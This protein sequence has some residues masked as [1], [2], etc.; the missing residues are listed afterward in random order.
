M[1]NVAF[2]NVMGDSLSA[3]YGLAPSQG[4]VALTA[5]RVGKTKPGWRVVNA[6]ISGETTSGGNSRLPQLLARYQPSV[7]L[8]ELGAND[9]LRGLLGQ[10]R[11]DVFAC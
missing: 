3:A 4:W 6:S 10:R 1:G 9:G 8:I 11:D 5:D 7:V 2:S